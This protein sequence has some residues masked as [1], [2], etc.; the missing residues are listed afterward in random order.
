MKPTS[1]AAALAVILFT[2]L[3]SG[4]TCDACKGNECCANQVTG[5]KCNNVAL[6]QKKSDCMSF[7]TT[8]VYASP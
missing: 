5:T 6:T 1:T 2:R 4:A 7:M 3:V 8:T